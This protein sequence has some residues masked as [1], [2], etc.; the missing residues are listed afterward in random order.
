MT[1]TLLYFRRSRTRAAS[2]GNVI[3]THQLFE[4][5]RDLG[6]TATEPPAMARIRGDLHAQNM[7]VDAE[8]WAS[9]VRTARAG[10]DGW[11]AN[12]PKEA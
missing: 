9:A 1:T 2:R 7:L 5:A 6:V 12:P 8:A 4:Q 3:R 10:G 11:D